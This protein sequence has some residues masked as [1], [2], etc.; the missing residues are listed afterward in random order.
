MLIDGWLPIGYVA[1][2][3]A[4]IGRV[5]FADAA[6]QIADTAG[7]GAILIAT[8][9]L[10]AR[11]RTEAFINDGDFDNF[12][13]GETTYF[14][15]SCG[16]SQTIAPLETARSPSTVN[17]A[18]AFAT[19]LKT[20]RA[21]HPDVNFAD[22]VYVESLGR[23]LPT[24]T[25]TLAISD[26]SILGRWL[27]GGAN[28]SID[29][30]GTLKKMMGWMGPDGLQRV[31]V[32]G[33]LQVQIEEIGISSAHDARS[34]T[35]ALGQANAG[36]AQGVPFVLAGRPKLEDFFNE[37]IIDIVAYPQRY[38]AMGIGF[39]AAVVLHGP[40]GCGKTFAVEQL[41]AY[42]GWPSFQIDASSVASPYIHETSKKVAEVFSQAMMQAPSVLVIDEMEAFLTDR[43]SGGGSGHHRVEEV[44][45]FLRRI[46]EATAN[47][48][49]VIAMTNRVETVD[50][51]ILR[52]GRFDHVIEVDPATLDDVA[53]L[54]VVLLKT[55]PVDDTVD[56]AAF[57]GEL[58]GR[59]LSD[60]AFVV[61]EAARLS[62]RAGDACIRQATLLAALAA[63]PSRTEAAGNSIGFY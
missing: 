22:A 31:I 25:G 12:T 1:P 28:I 17:Q 42:L 52:R 58:V 34:G 9:T 33:G 16:P 18:L 13:F 23:L 26:A 48:V 55:L 27:T 61:R 14:C 47:R 60:V 10:M 54:L 62:A 29:A 49:L 43:D 20:T 46:P 50:P 3:G 41:V 6:W 44:A 53:S 11:W 8:D 36:L 40:P 45:E 30:F 19:A 39:P 7:F 5:R 2:D 35:P 37:H 63:T 59:P 57:A 51:A 15:I 38:A 4:V 24:Y 32:A 21:I 56:P